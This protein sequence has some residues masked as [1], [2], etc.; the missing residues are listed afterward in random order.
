MGNKIKRID[1]TD[2][3]TLKP[4]RVFH[5]DKEN[6]MLVRTGVWKDGN[7]KYFC[8]TCGDPVRDVTNTETG[9]SCLDWIL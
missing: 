7:G 5:C 8:G 3:L 6:K 1:L 9:Q 2:T 4:R